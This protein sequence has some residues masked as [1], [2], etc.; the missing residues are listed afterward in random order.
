MPAKKDIFISPHPLLTFFFLPFLKTKFKKKGSCSVEEVPPGLDY[1]VV[2]YMYI[3]DFSCFLFFFRYKLSKATSL[4]MKR[5]SIINLL[6][7]IYDVVKIWK[8]LEDKQV[9]NE[10]QNLP[11]WLSKG[12]DLLCR[13]HSLLFFTI[14]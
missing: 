2:C 6:L 9:E 11:V 8:K 5:V 1:A 14:C 10:Y 3:R 13:A 12:N 4:R 7:K